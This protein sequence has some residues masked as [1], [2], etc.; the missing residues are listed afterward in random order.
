MKLIVKNADREKLRPLTVAERSLLIEERGEYNL[1]FV[2]FEIGRSAGKDIWA[3]CENSTTLPPNISGE[4]LRNLGLR[5]VRDQ[6]LIIPIWD[7][8]E[9]DSDEDWKYH[10]GQWVKI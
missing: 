4:S 9:E 3:A 2:T 8:H 10:G 5:F 6:L 7:P 1:R